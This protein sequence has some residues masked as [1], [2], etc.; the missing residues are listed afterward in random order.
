M[1][2]LTSTSG[3]RFVG[4]TSSSEL[5]STTFSLPLLTVMAVEGCCTIGLCASH[6]TTLP[7]TAAAA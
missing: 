6:P 5:L 1:S 7:T 3:L 2:L 4:S